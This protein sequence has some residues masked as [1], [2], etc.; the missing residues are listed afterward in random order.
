MY[1]NLSK[2]FP[3]KTTMSHHIRPP[4]PH[5]NRILTI[6]PIRT[7]FDEKRGASR[8]HSHALQR[9]VFLASIS[10]ALITTS[11]R[12]SSVW[13]CPSHWRWYRPRLALVQV[14]A[15]RLHHWRGHGAGLQRDRARTVV[16]PVNG[17]CTGTMPDTIQ[18]WTNSA[19]DAGSRRVTAIATHRA[20][21]SLRAVTSPPNITTRFVPPSLA[22]ASSGHKY[23]IILGD[24]ASVACHSRGGSSGAAASS[25]S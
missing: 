12:L 2:P 24:S 20:H 17:T 22:G 9:R 1:V 4:R 16:E 21:E 19:M 7:H 23:S 14:G 5:H 10:K 3:C 25:S 11:Y 18:P 13:S 15:D 8:H 6:P